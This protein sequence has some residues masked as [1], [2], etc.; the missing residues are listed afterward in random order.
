[1]LG[2]QLQYSSLPSILN[3]AW[4][5]RPRRIAVYSR[6]ELKQFE[7]QQEF[8]SSE[9]RYFIGDVR[10]RERLIRWQCAE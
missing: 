2:W 4:A 6:D 3:T 1:V 9:M 10:D 8:N 7:M 5:W